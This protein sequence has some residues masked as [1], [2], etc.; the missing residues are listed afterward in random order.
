MPILAILKM[1]VFM[2]S[3]KKYN[4]PYSILIALFLFMI[5]SCTT[6]YSA[7]TYLPS[8]L[9]NLALKQAL[10][11]G[12]GFLLIFLLIKMPKN[13]IDH[14]IKISYFVG[15][16]LL[17]LLLFL[18][19][20]I[21]GSK[22]WFMIPGIGSFQPSEFMKIILIL[23]LSLE[24]HNFYKNHQEVSMK[25]EFFF[26]CKI[27]IFVMIPSLLTFLEPD[28]GA[29]IIYLLITIGI[30]LV[31][32]LRRRWFFLGGAIFGIL[33]IPFLYFY[34]F[35]QDT[36]VDILGTD[37]FYRMDRILD[38]KKGEGL[39]LENSL[40]AI[41]SSGILGH[42]YNH[43]PL[44]FPESGT[45]FIFSVF[46]SNFGLLGSLFFILLLLFFDFSLLSLAQ[47]EKNTFY[48][49]V[50]IGGVSM[51]FYQQFQNM[52]MTIGLLPITGITLPFISYGG[53]SLLA[54]MI[55]MGILFNRLLQKKKQIN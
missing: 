13:F 40:T 52:S 42:G 8:Y 37:L 25:E 26:L 54:Y 43:T 19:K 28:T 9:G 41:G 24:V 34:F 45:D 5:I 38:W 39:Q 36:F 12:I 10:F 20:D 7:M 4:I 1:V 46:A 15:N 22:C 49:Y 6:I 31:S 50:I 35:Q 2:K 3:Y 33:L 30:L 18:G 27:L 17:F 48:K 51:F 29:V 53:S 11:Y 23:F 14:S 44:Y 55:F 16:L 47:K 21:N 32:P